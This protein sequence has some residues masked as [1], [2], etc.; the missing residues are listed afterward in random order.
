MS[1]L[2]TENRAKTVDAMRRHARD[3]GSPE[4]QITLLTQRIEA[5]NKNH[6]SRFKKDF[7]GKRGLLRLVNERRKQLAYLKRVD[8]ERYTTLLAQLDIRK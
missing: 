8:S 7:S 1:D 5:L 4:V 2:Y 6:F 3:T